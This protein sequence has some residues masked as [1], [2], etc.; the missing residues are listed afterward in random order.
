MAGRGPV[1]AAIEIASAIEAGRTLERDGPTDRSGPQYAL[2]PLNLSQT[3][4]V[5][6]NGRRIICFRCESIAL[7]CCARPLRLKT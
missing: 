1:H 2:N 7:P 5:V 6:V 3:G 4:R